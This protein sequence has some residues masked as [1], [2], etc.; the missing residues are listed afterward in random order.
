MSFYLSACLRVR[1]RERLCVCL[2]AYVPTPIHTP[3]HKHTRAH[4]RL[5]TDCKAQI[6]RVRRGGL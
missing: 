6:W 4:A 3:T 5:L 2:I 1:V